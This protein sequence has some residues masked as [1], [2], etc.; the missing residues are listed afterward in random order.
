[1]NDATINV[2]EKVSKP[3]EIVGAIKRLR[4]SK[5][6]LAASYLIGVMKFYEKK[7]PNPVLIPFIK[8]VLEKFK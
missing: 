4:D 7:P 3:E 8:K 5:D 6:R 2:F 1:M